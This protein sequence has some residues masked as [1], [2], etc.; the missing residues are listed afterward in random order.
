MRRETLRSW[1]EQEFPRGTE[2]RASG[3]ESPEESPEESK[4][5]E[6]DPT[7]R[8]L[9]DVSRGIDE[10]QGVKTIEEIQTLIG[11]ERPDALTPSQHRWIKHVAP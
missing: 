7:N 2:S 8:P 1:Y 11:Q 9:A 5:F 3:Q 4:D 6:R 10:R